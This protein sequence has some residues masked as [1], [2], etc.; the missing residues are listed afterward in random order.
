[1]CS[2]T[3]ALYLRTFPADNTFFCVTGYKVVRTRVFVILAH[4]MCAYH[5]NLLKEG[6]FYLTGVKLPLVPWKQVTFWKWRHVYCITECAICSTFKRA[7]WRTSLTKAL[8]KKLWCS[9]VVTSP[10]GP[11]R[12]GRCCAAAA[13]KLPSLYKFQTHKKSIH[14]ASM[15]T[16][17]VWRQDVICM[18]IMWILSTQ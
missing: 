10:Q 16:I 5:E 6:S 7:D 4:I 13:A 11:A 12:Y 3:V 14:T 9:D 1:M 2:A 15:A 8:A 17:F 18:L